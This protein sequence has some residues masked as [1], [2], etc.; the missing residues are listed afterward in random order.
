MC[1]LKT[2][3]FYGIKE[4]L[5]IRSVIANVDQ[6]SASITMSLQ[7]LMKEL[8]DANG[9]FGTFYTK[10]DS[11]KESTPGRFLE[12]ETAETNMHFVHT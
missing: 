4:S 11:M 7:T 3:N 1:Q 6:N 8:L 9:I 5:H 10:K 2:I 12:L